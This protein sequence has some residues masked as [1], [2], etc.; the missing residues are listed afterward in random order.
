MGT[1][2]RLLSSEGC[3]TEEAPTKR[4]NAVRFGRL[5]CRGLPSGEKYQNSSARK[6]EP[7]STETDIHCQVGRS[8][9]RELRLER[10]ARFQVVLAACARVACL[11]TIDCLLEIPA[12][13]PLVY[14]Y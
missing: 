11:I 3:V 2:L 10:R 9:R 1:D 13:P 4:V 5:G 6:A 7:L 12:L 14:A 8:S